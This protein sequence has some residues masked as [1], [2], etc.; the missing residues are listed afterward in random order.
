[1]GDAARGNAYKYDIE[2]GRDATGISIISGD[3]KKISQESREL[4]MEMSRHDS[5]HLGSSLS[6]VEIIAALY[7][8][9]KVVNGGDWV[10]LSKGHAAPALYAVLAE[11][12]MIER[13]ELP[14]IQ[15]IH[16]RL[17]GHP[18]VILPGVDASTGSLG[19]GLGFAVGLATALKLRGREGNVFVV[20]GDGELDE[21]QVWEAFMDAVNR[22]LDNLLMV[23]DANGFQLDG[24]VRPVK[25]RV[26]KAMEALGMEVSYVDGHDVDQLVSEV[27]RLINVRGRP[28]A[29]IARTIHGRG[30]P[31]IENTHLQRLDPPPRP[32]SSMRDSLGEALAAAVDEMEDLVVLTADVGG[33]TRA[34]MAR[35]SGRYIDVGISEQELVSAAAGL[36]AAGLRPVAV[37]FAMFLMRAWEQ[38]RNTVARMNLNVK[39]V[40]TH[41]GFSDIS[42]GSSHQSLEDIA[43]M[44]VLPNF[45]VV[46]PADA[47][48]VKRSLPE[49]LRHEGP[50]Y[51]RVGRD[52]SPSITDDLEYEFKLGRGV[53]LQDGSDVAVIG[54]GPV[55]W[56][57]VMAAK[58]LGKRGVSVSV[59]DMASVK[60]MDEDLVLKYAKRT[61]AIITVEEHM[62]AGGLGSSVSELLSAKYSVPVRMIGARSFG[63]SAR[64]VRDLLM[65]SGINYRTIMSEAMELLR[66]R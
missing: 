18:E 13:G 28:K 49:A 53:V 62:V 50:L 14:T 16:S 29:L 63:R 22:G 31:S 51:Y 34:S 46:V 41:A 33:P 55:L 38:A 4:L 60:P 47:A 39:L 59:I 20:L 24:A 23:V 17:Q 45:S 54:A 56:D 66:A 61:G 48:E 15:D 37:A 42:D 6:S 2:K 58:E 35:R 65:H 10:I 43:L 21:G 1:M 3:I 64:A 19:Q 9:G 8:I 25:E 44:R 5:I 32:L 57:A 11:L 52:Y 26:F 30:A 27:I 12:G 7:Y 40:G 36:A